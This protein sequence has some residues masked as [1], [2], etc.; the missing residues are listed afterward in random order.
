LV[1]LVVLAIGVGCAQK[2]A[3][4]KKEQRA[5]A[6]YKMGIFNLESGNYKEAISQFR[7]ALDVDPANPSF[8][9]SLGTAYSLDG[10]DELA[11]DS[12]KRALK[13]DPKNSEAH[14]NLGYIYAKEARWP[15][16]IAEFKA[17]LA[18]P[19]YGRPYSARLNLAQAYMQLG[20][21]DSAMEEYK[22]VLDLKPDSEVAHA[23]LGRAY[24]LSGQVERAIEEWEKALKINERQTGL[25]LELARAY[26][27][28][29]DQEKA[30]AALKKLIELD[31][32][33]PSAEEAKKQLQDL[34]K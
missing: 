18:N 4:L 32:R 16:A 20:N 22:K 34:E 21:I 31:P 8:H 7:K 2:D 3:Q 23:G 17:A 1:L 33:S 9:F 26:S 12:L 15:E 5:D 11:V 24:R 30:V 6:Y 19:D 28:K 13:L 25:Y 27:E 14:N 10:Q 29:G